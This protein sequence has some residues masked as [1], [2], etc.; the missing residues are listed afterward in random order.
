MDNL[1]T[2][3]SS[4]QAV[5]PTPFLNL[6]AAVARRK[7]LSKSTKLVY[8]CINAHAKRRKRDVCRIRQ[9][10]MCREI[11]AHPATVKRA[12]HQLR[13][14]PGPD[15]IPTTPPLIATVRTGRSSYYRLLPLVDT[16]GSEE[17]N[18]F[19][20]GESVPQADEIQQEQ[21]QDAPGSPNPIDRE[22][23]PP[24]AIEAP[25]S[26]IQ[27]D[28][29]P[30]GVSLEVQQVAELSEEEP[31]IAAKAK[32]NQQ[33]SQ[34]RGKKG[35]PTW[36]NLIE[37]VDTR[38]E[39]SIDAIQQAQE[40]ACNAPGS[41]TAT[42]TTDNPQDVDD[43]PA[44][45][46]AA[47]VDNSPG[48]SA[49]IAH[50]APVHSGEEEA[51]NRHKAKLKDS[52]PGLSPKATPAKNDFEQRGFERLDTPEGKVLIRLL[53]LLCYDWTVSDP[54]LTPQHRENRQRCNRRLVARFAGRYGLQALEFLIEKA[55]RTSLDNGAGCL[56]RML[57]GGL[58][59]QEWGKIHRQEMA[60]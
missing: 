29:T 32:E 23:S 9:D 48:R 44:D 37:P 53:T 28:K 51:G 2:T 7:D 20:A 16:E 47:I 1:S 41:T 4:T 3:P 22:D 55:E 42:D 45:T 58:F 46:S 54:A 52:M 56:R 39:V 13:G 19:D 34:G 11:D 38:E 26:A 60:A 35:L 30:S 25:E 18:P 10:V 17:P 36:A 57:N 43:A 12:L 50:S 27:A 6:P 5:N 8:G 49:A 15:G 59:P 40:S 21:A 24:K 14:S 33:Q 31:L